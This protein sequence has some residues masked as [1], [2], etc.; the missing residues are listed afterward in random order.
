MEP[1][2]DQ[3]AVTNRKGGLVFPT[4]IRGAEGQNSVENST[5]RPNSAQ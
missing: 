3:G 1:Y 4:P 2:E 5:Y